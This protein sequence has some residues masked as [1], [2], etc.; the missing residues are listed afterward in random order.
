MVGR[1]TGRAEHREAPC[2]SS[3]IDRYTRHEVAVRRA[4]GPS[5][6]TLSSTY[7]KHAHGPGARPWLWHP[8]RTYSLPTWSCRKN[9]FHSS[10]THCSTSSP[11]PARGR[12]QPPAAGPLPLPS[13]KPSPTAERPVRPQ[14]WVWPPAQEQPSGR[15]Q[16]RWPQESQK[17]RTTP[18]RPCAHGT[19]PACSELR[20]RF[21]PCTGRSSL[22]GELPVPW[23]A[24]RR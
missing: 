11:I 18:S 15:E 7:C 6:R 4:G 24:A 5:G 2:C 13:G 19:R 12:H 3:C 9:P 23:Q 10:G 14:L 21:H 22:R 8:P 16:P 17:L 20:N 1:K